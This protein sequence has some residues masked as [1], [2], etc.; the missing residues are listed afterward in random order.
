MVEVDLDEETAE[1]LNSIGGTL[2]TPNDIIYRALKAYDGEKGDE[3]DAESRPNVW[4]GVR[5]EVELK[6]FIHLKANQRERAVLSVLATYSPE[7][8]GMSTLQEELSSK[9]GMEVSRSL[10]GGIIG[11]LN[12]KVGSKPKLVEG[13]QGEEKE[14]RIPTEPEYL[15]EVLS[16]ELS[17]TR[18]LEEF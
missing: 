1:L 2:D 6:R 12:T 15:F 9:L 8:V 17:E 7:W 5:P 16:E 3:A 11:G 13:R 18:S 10:A 14:Y 4:R